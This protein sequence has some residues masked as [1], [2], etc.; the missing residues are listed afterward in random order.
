MTYLVV[1]WGRSS[2]HIISQFLFSHFSLLHW[3]AFVGR[4]DGSLSEN[5][6]AQW[7]RVQRPFTAFWWLTEKPGG[8]STNVQIWKLI[9]QDWFLMKQTAN[10]FFK[11]HIQKI[12]A[13]RIYEYIGFFLVKNVE[14]R[15]WSSDHTCDELPYA[16]H[17]SW[18]RERSMMLHICTS[19]LFW[20]W[21]HWSKGWR[22]TNQPPISS[23]FLF[24]CLLRLNIVACSWLSKIP[25][26]THLCNVCFA[27]SE[28]LWAKTDGRST[29]RIGKWLEIPH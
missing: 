11:I 24:R 21:S 28:G 14:S 27:C 1:D 15:K 6:A 25:S 22:S 29:H 18:L 17:S 4:E 23:D 8:I 2:S 5:F 10:I 13:Q 19:I 12:Q 9:F 3:K 16:K 20:R 26:A 7:A